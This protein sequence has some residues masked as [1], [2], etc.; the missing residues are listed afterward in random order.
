MK[1]KH[2]IENTQWLPG[3][4][5]GVDNPAV[6]VL[7]PTF[8]RAQSGLFKKAVE[9]V[10]N[11]TLAALELIIIDDASTDG[12]AEQIAAFMARD[13]RVSCLRHPVNIG[14]PAV[15]EFEGYQ[16]ARAEYLAFQFDDDEFNL[17]ALEK[18]R[19]AAI[20]LRAKFVYGYVDLMATNMET[21]K[22][23]TLHD[24][25]RGTT[26]QTVLHTLNYISNNAV[27]LH[28][29][30]IETVGFYDPN[31]AI[32][33]LCD[34]DLWR[35]CAQHYTL[36][37]SDF[38]VGTITGPATA[39]SLGHTYSMERWLS[40]EWMGL[41]RNEQL[42]PCNFA[43]VDVLHSPQELSLA[44]LQALSEIQ[45]QFKTR[46]WYP[47]APRAIPVRNPVIP[48]GYILVIVASHDAS[49]S[50]YFEGLRDGIQ[51]R[52]RIANASLMAGQLHEEMIGASAIVFCRAVFD[53]IWWIE[54]ARKLRI[55]H[56]YFIDD[57]LSELAKLPE[58]QLEYASYRT[59][60]LR[61][62]LESFQGV[63]CSTI[64]LAGYF[65]THKIHHQVR[66]LPPA[67]IPIE[68][69]DETAPNETV[70]GEVAILFFG[71]GH[72]G[73]AFLEFVLPAVIALSAKFPVRLIT[74]G[75][76]AE[77]CRQLVGLPSLRLLH[78][79]KETSY[80]LVTGKLKQLK[81]D[82]LVHPAHENPNNQF[83]TLNVL[84]NASQFNAVPVLS[85]CEP[86][87]HLVSGDIAHLVDANVAAW[88]ERLI[89]IASEANERMA[90]LSRLHAFVLRHYDGQLNAKLMVETL[91]AHAPAGP[92]LRQRRYDAVLQ[93]L[94]TQVAGLSGEAERL[95]QNAA[96][97]NGAVRPKAKVRFSVVGEFAKTTAH[98]FW[99]RMRTGLDKLQ[100]ISA[101][102]P[103]E[104]SRYTSHL[105]AV[106]TTA[107]ECICKT[108]ISQRTYREY[109]L[110]SEGTFNCVRIPLSFQPDK[111]G[112]LS[113]GVEIVA[114]DE[115]IVLN[116]TETFL[117]CAKNDVAY[118]NFKPISVVGT[119]WRIRLFVRGQAGVV[120]LYER[121][122]KSFLERIR[123]KPMPFFEIFPGAYTRT[124]G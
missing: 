103:Q 46:A 41:A 21:G 61:N 80:L 51:R 99:S 72:R 109:R 97:S 34:Y 48:D 39:D 94:K 90:L 106:S 44:S 16:K 31:I 122:P 114:P 45:E 67:K 115:R 79:E 64:K 108:P 49:V 70:V 66:V 100:E 105:Q 78:L 107:G 5:Y 10:L 24:F 15:S 17:D 43:E 92:V 101:C 71:G 81:L 123:S 116:A 84:I 30:V 3:S 69:F 76:R 74:V 36:H 26:P 25:G 11:Q 56:Y 82:I 77:V 95:R 19:S 9:S 58:Y 2:L 112:N 47:L 27:M 85:N 22:A 7:L 53:F 65:E 102:D 62:I 121:R 91:A 120:Y 12:T 86:F 1:V 93:I 73:N 55:P 23:F 42:L 32:T 68:L 54:Y 63:W 110:P 119:G 88:T 13:G 98:N 60:S 113:V 6:S 28:R 87:C 59:E 20:S 83:K 50:L 96:R 57:N 52:I 117:V 35:R 124:E 104:Y 4:L 40:Y 29:S 111:I 14:L 38:S 75:V 18:M 118:L 8:R 37:N 89:D 33:R